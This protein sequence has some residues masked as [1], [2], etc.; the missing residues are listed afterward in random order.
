MSTPKTA[1]RAR[2]STSANAMAQAE[3]KEQKKKLA[4]EEKEQRKIKREEQ[5][6]QKERKQKQ[7]NDEQLK[8]LEKKARNVLASKQRVTSKRT[9]SSSCKEPPSK[10]CCW[11]EEQGAVGE[12]EIDT[13]TCCVCFCLYTEDISG[14]DCIECGCRRW[15]H[16]DCG[17]KCVIGDD[18]NERFCPTRLESFSYT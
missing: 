11:E 3:E 5:K 13:N 12:A 17:E 4:I 18:E 2:L 9:R 16:K 8:K 10:R 15:L 1:P 7:K 6:H 14:V